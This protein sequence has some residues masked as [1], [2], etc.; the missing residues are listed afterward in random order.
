M[1]AL[2]YFTGANVGH[3]T[4]ARQ[5][6]MTPSTRLRNIYHHILPSATVPTLPSSSGRASATMA[7]DMTSEGCGEVPRVEVPSEYTPKG[8]QKTTPNGLNYYQV[9][10]AS[11]V[12]RSNFA[13]IQYYDVGSLTSSLMM[14][15]RHLATKTPDVL[16]L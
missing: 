13:V 15:E 14:K 3:L 8:I 12:T 4:K 7:P 5:L 2:T 11:G 6:S 9:V 1:S 16:V 10:P